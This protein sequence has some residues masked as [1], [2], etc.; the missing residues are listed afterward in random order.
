MKSF[1]RAALLAAVFTLLTGSVAG[2]NP[3]P[4]TCP[5]GGCSGGGH[6]LLVVPVAQQNPIP[7]TCP[8]GGCKNGPQ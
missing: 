4:P 5:P 8:P 7:P 1:T 3:I 6:L 2:Q